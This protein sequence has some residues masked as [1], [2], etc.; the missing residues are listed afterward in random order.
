[1]CKT[2][3]T[4]IHEYDVAEKWK[5][6]KWQ[7]V[8]RKAGKTVLPPD[9]PGLYRL[10]LMKKSKKIEFDNVRVCGKAEA[11]LYCENF[12][13]RNDLILSIGKTK[14]LRS[15]LG[16]H[17]GNNEKSNRLKKRCQQFFGL[18]DVSLDNLAESNMYLQYAVVYNWWERDLLESYGKA[19][20]CC[21][22]DLEI[23][24]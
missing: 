13:L 20:C 8:N 10:V 5:N 3:Y 18:Q 7:E 12:E 9:A 2:N 1:M 6:L 24:H 4:Q 17:F 22:F 15:R 16:Q 23:E 14:K 19:V 11:E 21:L